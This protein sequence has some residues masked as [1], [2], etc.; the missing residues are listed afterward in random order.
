MAIRPGPFFPGSTPSEKPAAVNVA[1]M[2]GHAT[3]REQV[4]GK[5]FKRHATSEEM[6]QMAKLTDQAMQEGAIGL[7]SGLEY[8]V[9]SY[10][11]TNELVLMSTPPHATAA[12]T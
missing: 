12:S 9:G 8:E 2:A 7:S 5:D 1:V 11:D 10:S 6:T 4:M 3:I